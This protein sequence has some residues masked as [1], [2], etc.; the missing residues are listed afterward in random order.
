M[1]H[2]RA[3]E[4]ERGETVR[5]ERRVYALP[6]GHRRRRRVAVLAVGALDAARRHVFLPEQ[7]AVR[8]PVGEQRYLRAA[9]AGGCEEEVILPDDRRGMPPAGDLNLP[10][11]IPGV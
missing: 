10:A 3:V 1:P 5:A 6:V 8:S 7:R 4:I 11:D 2:Q 9:V